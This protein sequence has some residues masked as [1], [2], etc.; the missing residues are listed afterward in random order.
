[1]QIILQKHADCAVKACVFVWVGGAMGGLSAIEVGGKGQ[2]KTS[3][4]TGNVTLEEKK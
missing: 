2:T 4:A 1:M 3:K